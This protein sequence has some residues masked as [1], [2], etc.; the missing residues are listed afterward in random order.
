MVPRV[1]GSGELRPG[2]VDG[3]RGEGVSHIQLLAFSLVYGL[4]YGGVFILMQ[5]KPLQL[6][7]GD[8]GFPHMQGFF[9]TWQRVGT[10]AGVSLTGVM[11][12]GADSEHA[13]SFSTPFKWLPLLAAL[14]PLRLQVCR[15]GGGSVRPHVRTRHHHHTKFCA[16]TR[17]HAHRCARVVHTPYSPWPAAM[18]LNLAHPF[19]C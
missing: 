19:L 12:R 10:I 9:L 18:G 17:A 11:A 15:C 1:N 4:G 13:G 6:Y 7:G 5:S 16:H 14:A 2:A 8:A 3:T